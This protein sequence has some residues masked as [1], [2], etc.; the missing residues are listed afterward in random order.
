[1]PVLII[2]DNVAISTMLSKFLKME[3]MKCTTSNSGRNGLEMIQK[4]EW[5]NILLDL[6]MPEFSGFDIL[7]ALKKDNMIKSKNI[8]L[9]TATEIS[10]EEI[11]A[12]KNSGVKSIIRKPVDLDVLLKVLEE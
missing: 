12:W 4:K 6:S 9:F 11:D 2:E 3:G 10:D 7:E 1:M 8:I 5:D